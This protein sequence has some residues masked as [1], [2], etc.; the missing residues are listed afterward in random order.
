MLS[1]VLTGLLLCNYL[2]CCLFPYSLSCLLDCKSHKGKNLV[3]FSGAPSV[4]QCDWQGLGS[5][6]TRV[7]F[8]GQAQWVKDLALSMLWLGLRLWLVSDLWPGSAICHGVAKSK[9]TRKTFVSFLIIIPGPIT[10]SGT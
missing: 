9:Q 1:F 6:E 3:S 5:T 2:T 10:V 8:P 4:A 7:Q